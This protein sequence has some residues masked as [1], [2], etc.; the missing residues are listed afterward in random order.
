MAHFGGLLEKVPKLGYP[1]GNRLGVMLA[2]PAPAENNTLSGD[3]S[4]LLIGGT[5]D[6]DQ[7]K[8]GVVVIVRPDGKSAT[9][10][11][12]KPDWVLT[13]GHV[14]G[15]QR[16][17]FWYPDPAVGARQTKV[18]QSTSGPIADRINNAKNCVYADSFS[19][20]PTGPADVALIG[21]APSNHIL[22]GSW[23]TGQ[24]YPTPT[25][26]TGGYLFNLANKAPPSNQQ[27]TLYGA[28]A[29]VLNSNNPR[30]GQ[31]AGTV[32]SGILNTIGTCQNYLCSYTT[33]L[34]CNQKN[35]IN[36]D[37]GGPVFAGDNTLVGIHKSGVCP[38]QDPE[39]TTVSAYVPVASVLDWIQATAN[40]Q[41]CVDART[42]MIGATPIGSTPLYQT[43]DEFQTYH[44]ML[45]KPDRVLIGFNSTVT[46]SLKEIFTIS[47]AC[48][49]QI[50]VPN[51]GLSIDGAQ[52]QP[53]SC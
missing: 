53:L 46:S 12:I 43:S 20:Y 40:T 5:I 27:V 48:G 13:A 50:N 11:M 4:G 18:C 35:S 26:T 44:C 16:F 45:G 51:C 49:A 24:T 30:E 15:E 41:N 6:P 47:D 2:A 1:K 7:M 22:N 32:R 42:Q 9:G 36:G 52:S 29:G 8:H 19:F 10:V 31:G 25:P 3:V 39:D 23:G 14:V 17:G 34:P 28:G 33:T 37:S 38:T 21:L